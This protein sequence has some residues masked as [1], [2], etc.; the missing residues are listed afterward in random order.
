MPLQ[1]GSG[2]FSGGKIC[3][4]YIYVYAIGDLKIKRGAVVGFS[5]QPFGKNKT[6]KNKMN[7]LVVR[8]MHDTGSHSKKQKKERK[9][10]LAE[11]L[12]RLKCSLYFPK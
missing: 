4:S 7:W 1:S 12:Q 3:P 10:N 5:F 6:Q 9:K 11:K 2:D 8:M